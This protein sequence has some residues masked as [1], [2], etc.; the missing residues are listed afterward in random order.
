MSSP[1][2]RRG[3]S[4]AHGATSCPSPS[5]RSC[6]CCTTK[7]RPCRRHKSGPPSR[8]SS[9]HRWRRW[10][11]AEPSTSRDLSLC[12][13]FYDALGLTIIASA[14]KPGD[15]SAPD[16]D[17]NSR[18]HLRRWRR[19]LSGSIWTSRSGL[20]PSHRYI[21]HTRMRQGFGRSL[22]PT[23]LQLRTRRLLLCALEMQI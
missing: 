23:V 20:H 11:D 9:A 6:R 13:F 10:V 16:L 8:V 4:L 3:S 15:R 5:V 19:C 17:F 12:A 2:C 18:S 7:C 22:L 1:P 21:Q 14:N